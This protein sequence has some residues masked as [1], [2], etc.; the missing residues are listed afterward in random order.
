MNDGT[1][2]SWT[3]DEPIFTSG[4][5]IS[6]DRY[7]NVYKSVYLYDAESESAELPCSKVPVRKT[8]VWRVLTETCCWVETTRTKYG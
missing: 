5:V 3:V 4:K 1:V 7:G 2:A 8:S 6:T